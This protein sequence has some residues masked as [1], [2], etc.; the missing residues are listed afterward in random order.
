M[1]QQQRVSPLVEGAFLALIMAL[2]GALAIYFMPV[3]FLID[4]VWGIPLIVIVKRYNIRTGLLTL[5]TTLFITG[6]LTD[7]VMTL[8]LVVKLAP[9]ALAY[10]LLFKRE[11]SPGVALAGGVVVCLISDFLTILGYLYLAKISIIP[12]EQAL[13]MQAQQFAMLYTKIGIDAVQAKQLAQSAVQLT[14][15]LVPSTLAVASVVRAFL[16]YILAVKVLRKL[17]YR[18]APLPSF[19]E[20]RIPWYSVWV[21]IIGLVMSLAGDQYKLTT[22][23]TIGKNLVFIVIPLFLLI[24]LAV[25]A[26]FMKVWEIPR[27]I[28]ILLLVTAV[29]NLT[30]SLVLVI[31]VGVFDPLVTFRKWKRPKD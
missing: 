15:A 5:T 14:L 27:W 7:P 26:H 29:I 18:V 1:T 21:L 31:L 12:T 2:M 20:W 10:S 11:V 16:T 4:Y 17:D 24:G 28:K 3:K 13:Q 9:L 8:L 23:A 25:I 6:M 22:L 30:G 19:R